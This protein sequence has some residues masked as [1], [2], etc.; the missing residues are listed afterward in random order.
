VTVALEGDPATATP[1]EFFFSFF[2]SK[3]V[4]KGDCIVSNQRRRPFFDRNRHPLTNFLG[5]PLIPPYLKTFS[6][7]AIVVENEFVV[8]NLSVAG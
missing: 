2:P 7:C 1:G 6:N 8:N 5:L 4:I 3:N